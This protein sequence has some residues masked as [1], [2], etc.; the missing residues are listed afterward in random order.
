MMGGACAFRCKGCRTVASLVGEVED[1]RQM[2]E[3]MK[4]MVTGQE[5]KEKRGETGDQVARL[6]EADEKEK[7]ERVTPDVRQKKAGMERRM[8]NTFR[9]KIETAI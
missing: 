2:M 3:I 7:C 9:Q 6:E 1:L 4:R 8:R 5:L